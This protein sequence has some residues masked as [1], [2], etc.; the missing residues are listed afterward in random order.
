VLDQSGVSGVKLVTTLGTTLTGIGLARTQ[1]DRKARG[2]VLTNA[3]F[4]AI[5]RSRLF[6]LPD[7]RHEAAAWSRWAESWPLPRVREG[8]R[9]LLEADRALK[10][11]RISD[12]RGVLTDVVLFLN[13]Q[14]REA[15]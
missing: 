4:E 2:S 10:S 6:G 5:K 14:K 1:F 9:G 12:E 13:V 15:A 8:L 3:M 11:T 7:W